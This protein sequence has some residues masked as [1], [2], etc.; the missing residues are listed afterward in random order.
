MLGLI[1][2]ISAAAAIGVAVGK[3]IVHLIK[4]AFN[5]LR[6]KIKEKLAKKRTQKVAVSSLQDMVESAMKNSRNDLSFEEMDAIAEV[7]DID[8]THIIAEVDNNGKVSDI[9]LI[10]AENVDSDVENLINR[11][12]EG[13]VTIS[14]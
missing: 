9:E 13:I 6:N 4:L 1:V 3:L 11:T 2:A 5:W 12:G 10:D 14:A 8:C 7:A